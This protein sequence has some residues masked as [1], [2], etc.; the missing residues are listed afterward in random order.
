MM[1][2][3]IILS[4]VAL[5]LLYYLQ[6]NYEKSDR[7]YTELRGGSLGSGTNVEVDNMG[8]DVTDG[9]RCVVGVG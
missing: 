6:C 7:A 8:G 5:S 4:S 9:V 2:D 1:P 3:P